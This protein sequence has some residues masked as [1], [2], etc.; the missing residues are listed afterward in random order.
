MSKRKDSDKTC[1]RLCTA[2]LR[3]NHTGAHKTGIYNELG[4]PPDQNWQN[5]YPVQSHRA[6]KMALEGQL[7]SL[8]ILALDEL[9]AKNIDIETE[10]K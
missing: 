9:N 1:R 7:S 10:K 8:V 6:I 4:K 3:V 5:R 2:P